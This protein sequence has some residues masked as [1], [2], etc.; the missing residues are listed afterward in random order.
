MKRTS[1]QI[2]FLTICL[3]LI[4]SATA[5][6]ASIDLTL[7]HSFPPKHSMQVQVFEP[8]AA[9][10]KE[11]TNG[12]VNIT[13]MPGGA[14][15]KPGDQYTLA[16]KGISGMSFILQDYTPG[17]FPMS[18]VFELPFMIPNSKIAAEAMWKTYSDHADYRKEYSKV[19]PLAFFCHAPGHFHTT[20]KP[21]RTI[22]DFK[23]IK[24]R[25]AGPYV[26]M[27]M[28]QFGAIPVDM[29]ITETYTSAE[30]GVVDGTVVPFEGLVIFKLHELMKYSTIT[31]FY[32]VNMALLMN[33]RAYDKLPDDVKKVF[34][35]NSGLGLSSWCGDEYDKAEGK[36]KQIAINKGIEIIELS[37]EDKDRLN[38]LTMPLREEWI[39]MVETRGLSGRPVLE[40][41]LS[42]LGHK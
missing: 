10:L 37:P 2:W 19:K 27:A 8:W 29:P 17:R 40:S 24:M 30:R 32:T 14:L 20:K 18:E 31:D 28:K 39:K 4:F 11:L 23:G 38:Q 25:T 42:Y 34:D 3:S 12:Q 5:I 16:E 22:A 15:G 1:A 41:A 7:S 9:K 35:A 21:L 26:T 36:M 33:Q 6:A 13:M